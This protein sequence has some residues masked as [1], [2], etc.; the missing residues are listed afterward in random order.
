MILKS[1]KYPCY[2]C[3]YKDKAKSNL[4]S[5]I[6]SVHMNVKYYSCNDCD[7]HYKSRTEVKQH[8]TY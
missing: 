2:H 4:K 5:H 1:L 7:K 8:I 3:E 6:E